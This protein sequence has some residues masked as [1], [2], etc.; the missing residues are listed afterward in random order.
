MYK[1]KKVLVAGGTGVLGIPMVKELVFRGAL[2]TVV[3]MEEENHALKYLPREAK[4][5][6]RNLLDLDQCKNVIS[7]QEF[8]INLAGTKRS[9]GIGYKGIS[10]FL[11]TML[12]LQTNIMDVSHSEGIERF[13]FVGSICE[14]PNLELR[15]EEDV[16]NGKPQQNDWISGVQKR[17][18]EAQAEAY[19]LDTGW[20]A[21]RIVRPSNVYGPFDN[22]SSEQGQVIPSLVAKLLAKPK[23]LEV[24][25]D[26]S[27]I[28]DFIYA[29]DVAFWSL[30]VL[31]KAPSNFPINLGSG[32]GTSIKEIAETLVE[33]K[34]GV[35]DIEYSSQ[36]PSGDLKR[37]LDT[38]RAKESIGFY[39]QTSIREGLEKTLYWAK[40][41]PQWAKEKYV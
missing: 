30:E 26:G 14:Y 3:G 41:N 1:G 17:I 21:V 34:G 24:M 28:R 22:F 35:I 15:T 31:E 10:K 7:G 9:V 32:L 8:V 23:K 5:L 40:E 2:V 33:L 25:G 6:K 13:L 4:Y 37:I 39:T 38:R 36:I 11:V 18:G 16:W 27:N 20:D 12:N 19:L 29:D